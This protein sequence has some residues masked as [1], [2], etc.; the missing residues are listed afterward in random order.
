MSEPAKCPFCEPD[1]KRVLFRLNR[2]FALW[3]GFPV[4]EGHALV[5]PYRH[6]SSWFDASAEERGELFE[7]IDAVRKEIE[8]RL[9]ADGFNIGINVGAAAGQTVSHLH[10]HVIPRRHGDVPDPRGGVR[11]VIPAKG[12]YLAPSTVPAT[13]QRASEPRLLEALL[14]TGDDNPL[15]AQLEN[16]LAGA[17]SLDVA[18]A[19]VMPSGVERLYPH[20]EDLLERG[21]TLRLLTGDYLEVS[22]PSALQRLV[23]LQALY[24]TDQCQLRMFESKGRS[25]HPK[26]YVV[27]RAGGGGAAYVGSSNLSALALVEGIEWNYRI[28]SSR[29]AEGWQR[30][31]D[32]FEALFRHVS[33]RN[34]DDLWLAQYR[35]RRR[36]P[37]DGKTGEDE[38]VEPPAPPPQPNLIQ[39]EAL[40]AL[41]RTREEGYR[42][43]LV[44]MATGL[45]KTWLAAFDSSDDRFRRIL[46]VAHRQEILNQSVATFRRIRP[47]ASI[48]LYMGSERATEV[49]ILFASIQT[50]SRNEHLRRFDPRAFDYVV[51]DEFHHASAA[52]YRRLIDHFEPE[53]LLGLTATPERTDGGDLLALCQENLVYR[54]LV[55]RAI[56]HGLLCSYDY[57]GVPDDVDYANIPWR[58]TRFDEEALTDAVATQQRAA[59]ILE[60]WRKRGGDRT[61]AFCVSQRHADFMR[62]FFAK[63]GVPSAAVHAGRTSDSR[64]VSLERLASGDLGVVFAVDMFNE[65]VD[66]P[67]IDTVM[68]LRPTESQI[69]WLQQFGRGLRKHGDKRLTVIDYIGNHRSFLL[70]A[71]TLLELAGGG[72]RALSAALERVEAGT[73]ELPPGC[74]VTYDLEALNIMRALLRIPADPAD[75]LREYYID[76]R[77][78]NGARPSASEAFHDGYLPRTARRAHG[79]WFG[80]VSTMGDLDG[81][82]RHALDIARPF[83]EALE[84]TKMT[85]SFKML[86]LLAMLNT[87]TLPGRG[88]RVDDLSAEFVR[89]ARRN[90]K[91]AADLGAGVDDASNARTLIE[92]NPIAAWTGEGA[93]PGGAAFEYSASVFRYR[94]S[95]PASARAGFQRLVRE[96][97]EWRLTEYLSRTDEA[98]LQDAFTMK[99][100]HSAGQPILFLPDRSKV[101]GIPEGWQSV[102]IDGRP[103]RANFVKIAVNVVRPAD[104]DDNALPAILRG[105]FGH[106]AG[107]PGTKHTVV[108]EH[109]EGEWVM[110]PATRRGDDEAEVFKRYSREQ[111]PRLFGDQFS[112]ARWNSGFVLITPQNPRHVVLLVTLHKGDMGSQFQYGDHFLAPDLFQWQSQNRT[113]QSGKHGA[114]ISGHSTLGASV[115]LF[116][117]SEKKRSGGAAAPFVYCGPV[118]FVDW[119]GEAPITVRW[120]LP[121]RLPDRLIAEFNVASSGDPPDSRNG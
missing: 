91:L 96:V 110:R 118:T 93:V 29:D 79:S 65:G 82:E 98:P 38:V 88:I 20:F 71:R 111:I 13:A 18:V 84:S 52:T 44:V 17:R 10:L 103:Y 120:R 80:F 112:E 54:C 47:D 60:Q 11:H 104:G 42:A 41:A 40:V 121:K 72:D 21:G 55:P 105:W 22:D 92:L 81:E 66:V 24:G 102:L 43:G 73:F 69:V 45:G 37:S 48:G 53:F 76:F 31:S 64:S 26:A 63:N 106:D 16:D 68:M 1:E 15:L 114:L 90:P 6:F 95:I 86:V 100:S 74:E 57:F 5:I 83:L 30:V 89:L 70:K 34:L 51:V 75:A 39:L 12:N 107:R 27:S 25:F 19:F 35:S 14:T 67:A 32:A 58:S 56:E 78:R 46:F 36:L 108:C 117:R 9:P 2:V 49:D 85:R 33:T 4:S 7:A 109:V 62:R 94:Q 113:K 77:E 87:D 61:L 59:N 99:V 28:V 97:A 116:V 115:H 119:E 8:S 23:D 3:D 50:L 101:A